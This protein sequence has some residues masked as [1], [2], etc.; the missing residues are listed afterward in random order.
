M[1]VFV[2]IKCKI[3]WNSLYF[4]YDCFRHGLEIQKIILVLL[5]LYF[6]SNILIIKLCEE[7]IGFYRMCA[8]LFILCVRFL[9]FEQTIHVVIES[10]VYYSN[11]YTHSNTCIWMTATK[12]MN[13][14]KKKMK[15]VCELEFVFYRTKT[16]SVCQLFLAYLIWWLFSLSSFYI[17]ILRFRIEIFI[18]LFFLSFH[19]ISL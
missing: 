5:V 14:K 3:Q 10:N 12:T 1:C 18:L 4:I 16:V 17:F 13:E 9:I 15:N 2:C 6:I 7:E 19:S 8:T 11:A